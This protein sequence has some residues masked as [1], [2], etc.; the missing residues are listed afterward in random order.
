VVSPEADRL[1]AARRAA[2]SVLAASGAQASKIDRGVHPDVLEVTRIDGKDRVGIEQIRDVIRA[3]YLAPTEARHKLC[4]ILQAEALTMEASNA[5]LKTLEE[6]PGEFR[7]LLFTTDPSELLPTIVSRSRIV[8]CGAPPCGLAVDQLEASGYDRDTARWLQQLPLRQGEMDALAGS[9]RDVAGFLQEAS[10][11]RMERNVATLI[12]ACGGEDPLARRQ[13]LLELLLRAQRRDPD[14]MTEGIRRLALWDR[15]AILVLLQ[16]L[17][18]VC[19][20]LGRSIPPLPPSVDPLG[21]GVHQQVGPVALRRLC[22]A[23]DSAHRG[24]AVYGPMEPIL[25]CL[26][27]HLGE[28]V[29]VH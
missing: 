17:Q 22:L 21:H 24:I 26:L 25:L 12:E 5:L 28:D 20:H 6:P 15:A 3:A 1:E 2:R 9:P 29:H 23:L 18:R 19:F 16:D 13:A 7:F 14:L 10:R 11:S 4:L 8:R 27:F